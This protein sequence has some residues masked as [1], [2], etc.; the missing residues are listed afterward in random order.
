[1]DRDVIMIFVPC[2]ENLVRTVR[3]KAVARSAPWLATLEIGHLL[4]L[5]MAHE[6]GH[7]L[8]LVHAPVGVM[9]ARFDMDAFFALRTSRLA[10]MPHER[11]RIREAML[12][13]AAV[14][15]VS[16]R[17]ASPGTRQVQSD[18]R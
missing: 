8:R 18:A 2:H 4:G 7:V 3:A 10:F 5:T 12:A 6:V 11:L 1:M 15:T 14:L 9:Q 17:A 16:T 13:R